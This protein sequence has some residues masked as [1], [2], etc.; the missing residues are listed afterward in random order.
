MDKK[1]SVIVGVIEI[2]KKNKIDRIYSQEI[3]D[4]IVEDSRELV[5]SGTM[6]VQA[7]APTNNGVMSLNNLIGKVDNIFIEDGWVK[8]EVAPV[9]T[10]IFKIMFY[11]GKLPWWKKALTFLGFFKNRELEQFKKTLKGRKLS[12]APVGS[13]SIDGKGNV[14]DD[15]QLLGFF[16]TSEPS[17][18]G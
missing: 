5:E 16:L 14:Q 17:F 9:Q 11:A 1:D 2:G 4:K 10:P 13:G 3:C 18:V 12:V 6:H 15:Y 7:D 8:V